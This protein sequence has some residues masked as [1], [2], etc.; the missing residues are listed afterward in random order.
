[1]KIESTIYDRW[2]EQTLEKARIELEDPENERLKYEYEQ[3]KR[4]LNNSSR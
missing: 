3:V 4:N 1:M 2:K